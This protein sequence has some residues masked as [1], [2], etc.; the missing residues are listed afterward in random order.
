MRIASTSRL[1]GLINI[2]AI[3][4]LV[5]LNDRLDDRMA[6][7][8]NITEMGEGDPRNADQDFDRVHPFQ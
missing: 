6:H 2:P 7:D 4:F 5:G 1:T 8:I 3:G